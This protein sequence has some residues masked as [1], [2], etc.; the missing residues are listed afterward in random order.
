MRRKAIG[1]RKVFGVVAGLAFAGVLVMLYATRAGIGVTPDS[2]VYFD[3]AHN[4]ASGKGLVAISGAGP[5]LIP[6]THYPPLYS[7]ILALTLSS[8]A[9]GETA[10]RWLNAILFGANIF[11][12]GISIAF[13]A[14]NSFWFPVSGAILTLVAPDVL[15]IH[16]VA[17][18]EPLYLLLTLGGLLSLGV[19][20]QNQ[21]RRFLLAGSILIALSFLTRYVGI[22][23]VATGVFALL[24]LNAK[25]S[26]PEAV[27]PTSLFK[28]EFLRRKI[29]DT[30][31]FL[32]V[33]CLPVALWS[34]RNRA[35]A[36]GASDRQLA[37]HPVKLRQIVSAFSTAAQWLL[38][39]K[40]RLDVRFLAF[41]VEF[42]VLASL[43]IYFMKKG[44]KTLG[45]SE[46]ESQSKLPHLLVI[47]VISY[48]AVLIGTITFFETDNVLDSRSLL[49]VH[50]AGLV[51][52][53]CLGWL[54]YRRLPMSGSVR[55]IFVILPLLLAGSYT[56]RSARWLVLVQNDASG[57]AARD[58]KESE[59][60]AQIRKL[61]AGIPIYSNGVDAIYYLTARRALDIP[62]P[63]I[64]GTGQPNPNYDQELARMREELRQHNGAIV[65]FNTLPERWFLPSEIELR[66][67]LPLTEVATAPDGS[68]L[69]L[70]VNSE[71]APAR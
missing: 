46:D 40:V 26:K 14:R 51:L 64:H 1:R 17:L 53:P 36:G 27:R 62:A 15:A 30:L 66:T 57:Y 52:V 41:I 10:A 3:A 59:T 44:R 5:E 39:G 55:A 56:F 35:V 34:L 13:S 31:I 21:R 11:L 9:T 38:L 16:S 70:N 24:L 43:T 67:R 61:P 60:I 32:C 58:W 42:L 7:S 6:L 47:F 8:G 22:A 48:V 71:N 54:G 19:Y 20:F 4:L 45:R 2:T 49:P 65:Y 37:F 50:F 33:S 18:T 68:I 12:V 25:E 29:F 23:T 63:I 28:V 69:K